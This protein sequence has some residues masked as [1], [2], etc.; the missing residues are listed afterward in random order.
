MLQPILDKFGK[1]NELS[2]QDA[3]S[4]LRIKNLSSDYY[5]LLKSTHALSLESYGKQGYI[6]L[7]IGINNAPC[8]GNCKFC[9]L[10]SNVGTPT[11][12][13]EL[14]IQDILCQ[15]E[16]ADMS[17]VDSLFLMCTADYDF[18]QFC[19]IGKTVRQAIPATTKMVA[20]LGDFDTAQAQLL[21]DAGFNSVY[22]LVR[23]RESIDTDIAVEKRI[24]TLDAVTQSNMELYYCIEPIGSEHTYEELAEEMIRAREYGVEVMAVMS[25]VP[26]AGTAFEN[27]KELDEVELAKIT[28]VTRLVT[29]PKR[30]MNIHEP[31]TIPLLAGVNQL[32]AEIGINP[33]DT[34]PNTQ[35]SRGRSISQAQSMLHMAGFTV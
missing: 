11:E 21:E 15:I 17:K 31:K 24:A 8:S 30:S 28:A 34:H 33:R 5:D 35:N 4:L 16:H 2:K 14:H 19:E 26:V 10:A 6:F 29:N 12:A 22:H 18:H 25:R 32:Y 1:G 27:M 3:L 23:L 13:T 7:Q 20:N 9:S